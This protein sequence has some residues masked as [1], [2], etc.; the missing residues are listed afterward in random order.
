[1]FKKIKIFFKVIEWIAFIVLLCLLFVVISPKLPFKNLPKSFVVV[2]GSMEPTI[3]TGSVA[4]TKTADPK[5]LKSG[6]IIA[7]TSPSN[8]KDTILHRVNSISS[9]DPLLFKTKGDN[10]NDIDA[11][12]VQDVGVKG[13]Y[14]FAIPY[15]GSLAAILRQPWGFSV[16]VGI[17]ALIF[18]IIQIINIK[19]AIDDEVNRKV[20]QK[21]QQTGTTIEIKPKSTTNL[22]SLI[23]FFLFSAAILGINHISQ[24]KALYSDSVVVSGITIS[25]ADFIKPSIPTNLH[26]S[27]PNVV[28]GGH[29]NSYTI[30]AEWD[31]STDNQGILKYEYFITY[32]KIGG[33]FGTWSTF[34]TPSQYSGVFNQ[35]E[36]I[37]KFKVRAYDSNGNISDWSNECSITYDKTLPTS[38]ITKPWNSDH[39]NDVN[40]PIIWFWDGKIEGTASDNFELDHVELSIYR[41][42]VNLYWNGNSWVNGTE[43]TTRVRA[44]G[45][46][47][48]SYQIDPM[49]IP[50]GKFKIVAHAVDKAGN[51][52]NSATIEFEN[53]A[54]PIP[55]TTTN[56]DPQIG[57][58]S[59][60]STNKINL[61]IDNFSKP[62][63]Y[64][65]LYTGN[66]VEKGLIGKITA[67]EITNSTY[68]KDFYFGICSAGG[69]CV[70]DEIL[71][72]SNII[73]NISGG[74][75]ITKTFTY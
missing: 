43:L 4:F 73:V 75:T 9:T 64:E 65:I 3:K 28:C 35:A 10:N 67:D 23:F 50:L 32:P 27:N 24:A 31:D 26:W 69:T 48:W 15:L 34:V 16:V 57:L 62:S 60:H 1:M 66:G 37:H 61:K 53:S 41:Q 14:F 44:N 70:G 21:L 45:T 46:N 25:I 11:W 2:S 39:D 30:T 51:I 17:P 40:F 56:T 8:S 54:T 20:A 22:K 13:V 36:G 18:I 49:Y 72:G 59:N 12:D 71:S 19:K 33:G 63:D 38:T 42:I 5:N 29:T 7:F 68:S 55:D 58:S 47:N 52:E 74:Y 6:D